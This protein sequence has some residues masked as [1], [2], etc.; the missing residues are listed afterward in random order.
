MFYCACYFA[1]ILF[2]LARVMLMCLGCCLIFIFIYIFFLYNRNWS[3]QLGANWLWMLYF[4]SVQ[5]NKHNTNRWMECMKTAILHLKKC[6]LLF[7]LIY[8]LYMFTV[9]ILY[10]PI[11]SHNIIYISIKKKSTTS[12]N[13]DL[14]A[15]SWKDLIIT[16]AIY[17]DLVFQAALSLHY[18]LSLS[19]FSY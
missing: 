16:F 14:I 6:L 19:L 8:I 17:L 4:F 3:L 1:L 9:A 12:E 10:L 2:T 18:T 7:Y 5:T 13:R 15:S 11:L